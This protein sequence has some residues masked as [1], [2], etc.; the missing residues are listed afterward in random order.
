MSCWLTVS[1]A[2]S[3]PQSLLVH[4]LGGPMFMRSSQGQSFGAYL[5]LLP[6]DRPPCRSQAI[7]LQLHLMG[8]GAAMQSRSQATDDCEQ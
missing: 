1:S 2:G 7:L 4:A 3:G 6:S 5:K 8:C